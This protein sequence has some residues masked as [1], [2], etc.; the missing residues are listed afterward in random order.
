MKWLLALLLPASFRSDACS[1]FSRAAARSVHVSGRRRTAA[2]RAAISAET[3]AEAMD[4][5]IHRI[6]GRSGDRLTD[7]PQVGDAA[8]N[9]AEATRLFLDKRRR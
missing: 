7:H 1:E 2:V 5:T 9:V 8:M 3:R 4:A 6:E